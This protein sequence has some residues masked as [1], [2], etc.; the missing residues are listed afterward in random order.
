MSYKELIDSFNPIIYSK[1]VTITSYEKLML[2]VALELEDKKIP[3]T[4]NYLCIS[5]FKIFPDAFC[6]DDE[7]K[8]FPSIDRLNRTMMHLKYV[9]KGMPYL[10]GSIKT[11]Y[12]ITKLGR[13]LAMEVK[14]VIDN[15]EVNKTIK[16]P[17]VDSHKKG[18]SRDYLLFIDGL[19]YRDYLNTNVI[20]FMYI[21]KF[22]KIT[23][24]TQIKTTKENLKNILNYA[25]E[26]K[27]KKCIVFVEEVLKKI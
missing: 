5:A 26:K 12:S 4:F 21:W 18:Y 3:L 20:D 8:E 7:F 1:Y 24:F 22:F 23:P 15:S 27:D 11:G 13:A 25:K 10:A 19:E 14:S 2:Y 6:C 9:Q 17:V 16:A